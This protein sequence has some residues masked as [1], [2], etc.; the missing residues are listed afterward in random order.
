MCNNAR[1]RNKI[2]GEKTQQSP[3]FPTWLSIVCTIH[4]ACTKPKLPIAFVM[5]ACVC[6]HGAHH[7]TTSKDCTLSFHVHR[8][9]HSGPSHNRNEAK[10]ERERESTILPNNQILQLKF[11]CWMDIFNFSPS[12]SHTRTYTYTN[13]YK[14]A[15]ITTMHANFYSHKK[16]IDQN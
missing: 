13:A 5:S 7:C 9:Q 16:M 2:K 10:R 1:I 12:R 11:I 6:V 15:H 14:S 3:N 4:V 8:A